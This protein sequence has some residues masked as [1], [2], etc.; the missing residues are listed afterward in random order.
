MC[1]L[2]CRQ[3]GQNLIRQ[4]ATHQRGEAER[5]GRAEWSRE[6]WDWVVRGRNR[7]REAVG[8]VD[9]LVMGWDRSY[10]HWQQPF[11]PFLFSDQ[12]QLKSCCRSEATLSRAGGL[13]RGKQ[14][15][16]PL[17]S[18]LCHHP[19]IGSTTLLFG[20]TALVGE[21]HRIGPLNLLVLR[22][23][24]EPNIIVVLFKPFTQVHL[25][26]FSQTCA[27]ISRCVDLAFAWLWCVC[28]I[29]VGQGSF[30]LD[31]VPDA[32]LNAVYI[33]G[34]VPKAKSEEALK[35]TLPWNRARILF[36]LGVMYRSWVMFMWRI[37]GCS[38]TTHL[39]P[40][41]LFFATERDHE[42]I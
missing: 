21:Q 8:R 1:L 25:V 3:G 32:D 41:S 6:G 35:S 20:S 28:D 18:L 2:K 34:S 22:K 9:L 12:C 7:S 16:F 24:E 26:R 19:L 23:E 30:L 31:G 38:D 15:P 14:F 33:P 10:P 5:W 4:E 27:H 29:S 40:H 37:W 39:G 11:Y 36:S 17:W 13:W 42:L